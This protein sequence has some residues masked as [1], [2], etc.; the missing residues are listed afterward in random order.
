MILDS[1]GKPIQRQMTAQA[2]IFV[3][4]DGEVWE[5]LKPYNVPDWLKDN[6]VMGYMLNG[7]VVSLENTGPFYCAEALSGLEALH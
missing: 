4:D 1:Q 2:V 7:E 3:S 5:P 6:D